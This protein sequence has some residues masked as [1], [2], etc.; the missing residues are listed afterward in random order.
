MHEQDFTDGEAES[1]RG[2]PLVR[3]SFDLLHQ[4]RETVLATVYWNDDGNAVR[5]G[6]RHGH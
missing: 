1:V 4:R 6:A 5:S 3:Q 2:C